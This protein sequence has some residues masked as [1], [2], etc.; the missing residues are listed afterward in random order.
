VS[1]GPGIASNEGFRLWA[2]DYDAAPNALLALEMRILSER[3][4]LLPGTRFLDAGSGTGRWMKWAHSRGAKVFGIDSCR[5]MLAQA[6]RK[7]GLQGR[8]V[9][10]DISAIPLKDSAVD[11]ALCSFTMAYVASPTHALRAMARVSRYVIVSDLHPDAVRAGC[12]RSFRSGHQRFELQHFD[13]SIADL[14]RHARQAG[15][16]RDWR[17]EASFGEPERCIFEAAGKEEA[18]RNICGIHAVLITSWRKSFD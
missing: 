15:L 9:L 13:H 4:R 18:F 3:L 2:A 5:A 16:R 1:S 17:I 12:T 7:P 10:A 14:D 8:S 11:I 6:E